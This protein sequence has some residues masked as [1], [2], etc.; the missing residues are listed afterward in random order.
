[1]WCAENRGKTKWKFQQK[2][3]RFCLE[4]H[5]MAKI[6]VIFFKQ[7]INLQY[8]DVS[9]FS[10]FQHNFSRM[11]WKEIKG[12]TRN[13]FDDILQH[14]LWGIFGI[15][16]VCFR[17][18]GKYFI[19]NLLKKI[20]KFQGFSGKSLNSEDENYFIEFLKCLIIHFQENHISKFP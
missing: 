19:D 10:F 17:K 14:F 1:M 2:I 20:W 18:I 11:I 12:W 7:N 13:I 8:L 6:A 3:P 16:F 15:W 5:I 4:N 9:R